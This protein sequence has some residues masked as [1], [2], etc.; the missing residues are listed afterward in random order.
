MVGISVCVA[1]TALGAMI[2]IFQ[3]LPG[4]LQVGYVVKLHF[5][6]SGGV[7]ESSDVLL[8]GKRIGRVTGVRFADDDPRK[9]IE[10]TA[11]IN[12]D[13]NIPGDV[14]AYVGVRG[15]AGGAVVQ[16]RSDGYPPGADRKDPS[17][18][19]LAWIPKTGQFAI[20]G[21]M[22]R[23]GG[24]LIP[25]ELRRQIGQASM[26]IK[27]LADK[28]DLFFTPPQPTT[29]PG[30]TPPAEALPPANIYTTLAKLDAALDA[31]TKTLGDAENQ[32]NFRES[33]KKLSNAL[34]SFQKAADAAREGVAE[35]RELFGKAKLTFTEVTNAT[36]SAS[37]RFD[38]LAGRLIDD[39]D[40]LGD[41]LTS[42]RRFAAKLDSGDG[43]AGKLIN[44]SELYHNLV[45]A[46]AQFKT[47][48]DQLEDLLAEWKQNGVKVKLK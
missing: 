1:L 12:S 8:F 34:D 45:D 5:P 29:A 17:G 40:R 37:K 2:I 19:P 41:V 14:N 31:V 30:Q 26:S 35:A 46:S 28:L 9:R 25:A 39:A 33:L 20:Q 42:F 10:I 15:F 38:D 4:F 7:T 27:R 11:L 16:L 22:A 18:Q 47:A 48:L 21:Q 6:D 32:A 3:E 24:G 36:K 43:T 13:V 23:G 44:D